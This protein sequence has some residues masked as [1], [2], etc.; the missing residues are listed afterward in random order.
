[1]MNA[2]PNH[3]RRLGRNRHHDD[4]PCYNALPDRL[5]I[6]SFSSISDP[7]FFT[8]LLSMNSTNMTTILSLWSNNHSYF[9]GEIIMIIVLVF[10]L[11]LILKDICCCCCNTK[12]TPSF[13][14]S[15]MT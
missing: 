11:L 3:P 15:L 6:K 12:M 4:G 7:N 1:M 14:P 5:S 8:M 2:T 9:I 10:L 13:M